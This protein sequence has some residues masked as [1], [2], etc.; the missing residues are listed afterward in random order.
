M[1]KLSF[2]KVS[3]IMLLLGLAT[4]MSA[5][6]FITLVQF[7]N[8]FGEQPATPL[9]QGADGNLYGTA[10]I[11]GTG[12]GGTFFQ[13]LPGGSVNILY[14]FC[15]QGSG[16]SDGFGPI[17]G[18]LPSLDGN[19]YGITWSG[20][21]YS[22]GSIFQITPQGVLT[23]VYS[24]CAQINCADGERPTQLVEGN[25]GNFYGTTNTG[26]RYDHG[27]FFRMTPDGTL[28]TVTSFKSGANNPN[29]GLMQASDGNFY[30]TASGIVGTYGAIVRITPGGKL[31]TVHAFCLGGY[32]CA[33]GSDPFGTVVQG[34]D[35]NLYGTT[36]F[37]GSANSGTAFKIVPGGALTQIYNFCPQ[38]DCT[39]GAGPINGLLLASDGNFYGVTQYGGTGTNPDCNFG[40]GG[41]YKLTPAGSLTMLHDFCVKGGTFCSDGLNPLTPIPPLTQATTGVIVS[42]T[43]WGGSKCGDCGTAFSLAAGLR[44]FVAA[45]PNSGSPGATISIRGNKLTGSTGVAF[46]GVS[47]TFTVISDN[48]IQAQVPAGTTKGT[49]KVTT[50]NGVLTSNIQF[51]VLK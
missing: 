22:A 37:G 49:I 50:P 23:S 16:C 32:P 15:S 4:S 51:E 48:E 38:N 5:Q 30:G 35:G 18:L 39:N 10:S 41:V 26:G 43:Q 12:G 42:T 29:A 9:V 11:A 24:F 21:R 40:C 2:R 19:F 27:T 36:A 7:D 46:G 25:D 1:T 47:A 3:F 8:T 14:D 44:P 17:G 45:V 28:T 33:D 13:L 20:G 31:S 34:N 6:T